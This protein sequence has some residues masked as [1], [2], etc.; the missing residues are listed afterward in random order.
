MSDKFTLKLENYFDYYG[1]S[2]GF[3]DY[4]S[5]D[6][7]ILYGGRNI[8]TT[9]NTL[10][11]RY[12]FKNDMSLALSG[13]Y[14]WSEGT[15]NKLYLLTSEGELE[16]MN[17]TDLSGYNFN[18]NYFTIDL[19]YNWQFAPGSS[20][21]ATFKNIIL[22]DD[23]NTNFSHLENFNHTLTAP[24]TNSISLKFLYYLDYQYFVK[25]KA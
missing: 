24:Q 7:S 18:S 19:V 23:S 9:V 11:G 6:N 8:T 17:F 12:L 3:V 2:R 20:F 21:I 16:P 10:T 15:Y 5:T 1:S 4:N 22:T 14:Y 25:K 13:R